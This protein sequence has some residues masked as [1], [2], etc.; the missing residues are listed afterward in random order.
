MSLPG[1]QKCDLQVKTVPKCL[2]TQNKKPLTLVEYV[3]DPKREESLIGL[4]Y[5]VEIKILDSDQSIVKCNLCAVKGKMATMKEH[6]V[7]SQHIKAYMEKHYYSVYQS[8]RKSA[9]EK[10]HLARLLKDYAKEIERAEGTQGVKI[11]YVSAADMKK[12]QDQS[13]AGKEEKMEFDA[14]QKK[15]QVLDNRQIALDY[16][17]K[18]K[19]SS[20]EEA[21]IVLNLTQQLSDQLEQYFLKYK[22]LDVLES[23]I[24]D[25]IS[26]TSTSAPMNFPPNVQENLHPTSPANQGLKSVKE[27]KW[28]T[29]GPSSSSVCPTTSAHSFGSMSVKLGDT[30]GL[31]RKPELSEDDSDKCDVQE[32]RSAPEFQSR[33]KKRDKEHYNFSTIHTSSLSYMND[34][35]FPQHSSAEVSSSHSSLIAAT[36]TQISAPKETYGGKMQMVKDTQNSSPQDRPNDNISKIKAVQEVK[37]PNDTDTAKLSDLGAEKNSAIPEQS[38]PSSSYSSQA[39]SERTSSSH[40]QGKTSKTLSPDILQLLK[41]K[42]ANTVTN[43]LRTLSPFYPALQEVNLE[44]LAQVLVNT[45]VLD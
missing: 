7:G 14:E 44:I 35:G 38:P 43:I 23:T 29:E 2:D 1:Q 30:R 34:L 33:K 26:T 28:H 18:F 24:P 37:K 41:G 9:Y 10:K 45:G 11:E 27:M 40:T 20:R 5:V 21:T 36:C 12:E 17:E 42:D 4:Q 22:G 3:E 31:K 19:I 25:R 32:S 16:S 8:L 13:M 15:F 39:S 6:L